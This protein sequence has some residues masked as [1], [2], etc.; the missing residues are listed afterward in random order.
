MDNGEELMN[1]DAAVDATRLATS[2]TVWLA[3]IPVVAYLTVFSYYSGYFGV[4]NLPPQLIEFSIVQVFTVAVAIVGIAIVVFFWG[5]LAISAVSGL[6]DILAKRLRR[7]IIIFFIYIGLIIATQSPQN[8]RNLHWFALGGVVFVLL[9][10]LLLPL[11]TERREPGYLNKLRAAEARRDRSSK[12]ESLGGPFERLLKLMG[13]WL[14]AAVVLLIFVYGIGK[15]HALTRK[16]FYVST[17]DANLVVL[18]MGQDRAILAPYN[19]NTRV[20][21][22]QFSILEVTQLPRVLQYAE[23]G[24]LTLE[25]ARAVTFVTQTTPTTDLKEQVDVADS[26]EATKTAEDRCRRR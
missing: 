17:A 18:W 15:Y 19:P 20:I 26:T 11:L 14:A 21:E 10:E 13:P 16:S 9:T 12:E 2:A 24:P 7:G 6:P 22:R 4:F 23:V 8:L 1:D 25:Q 3:G 5:D